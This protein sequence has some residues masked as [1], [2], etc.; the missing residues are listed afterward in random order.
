[1][2]RSKGTTVNNNLSRGLITEATGLNFPDNAVT[3]TWNCIHEKVGKVTRRRGIDVEGNAQALSYTSSTGV[4][5]EFIWDAVALT[6]GYTFLVLQMGSQVHFFELTNDDGLSTEVKPVS[7]NLSSYKAPGASQIARQPCFFASGSGYLFITHPQ[8]NP[9][10][11]RYNEYE[12]EF[13]AAEIP[14]R[15]RDFEGLDDQLAIEENPSSLSTEHHYNLMNQGWFK[16]V[17]TG[18]RNNELQGQVLLTPE[19]GDGLLNWEN[20]S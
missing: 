4:I 15:V 9:I 18:N 5:K 16:K 20:I 17:R 14:L 2:P 10:I 6:G 19:T 11:I 7:V 3:E 12:D 13:Q 8:C 1:M